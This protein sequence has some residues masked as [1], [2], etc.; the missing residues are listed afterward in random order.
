MVSINVLN[1][2]QQHYEKN[3]P[4][5]VKEHKGEYLL[6]KQGHMGEIIE[7][8]YKT[9]SELP[10]ITEETMNSL[11][12]TTFTE[13]IPNRILTQ[14]ESLENFRKFLGISKK[15]ENNLVNRLKKI[16]RY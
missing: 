13:R 9:E 3:L 7:S 6:L 14:K 12:P 5:Y 16:K 2:M 11:G 1:E 4:K 15:A 8:F 10:S